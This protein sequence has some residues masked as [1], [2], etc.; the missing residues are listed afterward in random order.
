M[1][2]HVLQ[3]LPNGRVCSR[4]MARGEE[5]LHGSAAGALGRSG[6]AG[7]SHTFRVRH[8]RQISVNVC[9]LLC[10]NCPLHQH[11]TMSAP[12]AMCVQ[13][14]SQII[15][16]TANDIRNLATVSICVARFPAAQNQPHYGV[17]T[18]LCLFVR[19]RMNRPGDILCKEWQKGISLAGNF[20]MP[21]T[22]QN[23]EGT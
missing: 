5:T 23:H 11:R 1:W 3:L 6:F 19:T 17:Y 10:N 22:R 21:S 15:T 7:E 18:L 9:L 20:S 4:H 8:I 16:V 13:S 14:H 12:R 2:G